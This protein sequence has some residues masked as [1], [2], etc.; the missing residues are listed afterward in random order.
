VSIA[1]DVTARWTAS[2]EVPVAAPWRKDYDQTAPPAEWPNRFDL[3]TWALFVARRGGARVGG[4]V[5]ASG[6]GPIDLPGGATDV[7]LV[8]DLR[9]A[10]DARGTGVGTALWGAAVGSA[11]ARGCGILAVETQDVNAGACRFYAGRGCRV[12]AEIPGAYARFPDERLLLWR[13]D[14]A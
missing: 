11:R 4:V 7:A 3:S 12:A 6:L 1:F 9:V 5:I 8:W 13:L 2:G 10:P 14:L